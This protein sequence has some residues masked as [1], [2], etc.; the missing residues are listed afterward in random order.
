MLFIIYLVLSFIACHPSN[1]HINEKTWSMVPQKFTKMSLFHSRKTL[2]FNA[3][4]EIAY[5]SSVMKTIQIN[6][7]LLGN[8]DLCTEDYFPFLLPFL[9]L[10]FSFHFPFFKTCCLFFSTFIIKTF[11]VV[12]PC[13]KTWRWSQNSGNSWGKGRL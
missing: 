12:F 9:L 3:Y 10:F 2:W 6:V 4:S 8:F 7:H 11:R 5:F 13:H 1:I